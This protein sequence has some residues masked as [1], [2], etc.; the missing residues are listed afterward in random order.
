MRPT[1]TDLTLDLERAA[2]ARLKRGE[3]VRGHIGFKEEA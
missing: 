1:R 3:G 2:G